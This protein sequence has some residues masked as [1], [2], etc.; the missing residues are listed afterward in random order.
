MQILQIEVYEIRFL[1]F[2]V[3]WLSHSK[4]PYQREHLTFGIL[5]LKQFKAFPHYSWVISNL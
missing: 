2:N 5:S 1:I 4:I 3:H